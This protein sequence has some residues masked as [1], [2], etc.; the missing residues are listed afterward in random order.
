MP[1]FTPIKA[2]SVEPFEIGMEDSLERVKAHMFP[3]L[4]EAW[5]GERLEEEEIVIDLPVIGDSF[6]WPGDY[7]VVLSND[8]RVA[9]SQRSFL[10]NYAYDTGTT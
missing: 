4:T 5:F 9:I 3:E 6:V 2:V 10:E 7:V 1:V 8:E